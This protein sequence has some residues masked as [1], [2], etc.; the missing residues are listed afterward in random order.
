MRDSIIGIATGLRAGR[1][2]V[3]IP[4]RAQGS[5]VL[6]N[7]GVLCRGKA[8]GCEDYRC[9]NP[10]C[11]HGLDMKIYTSFTRSDGRF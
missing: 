10:T 7:S 5:S 6:Q 11:I 3:G 8:V 1:S 2:G 4:V 9:P